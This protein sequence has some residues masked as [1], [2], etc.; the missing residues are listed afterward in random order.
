MASR[1]ILSLGLEVVLA[2]GRILGGLNKLKKD[3]TGYDLKNI[4]VGA[5]GTLG[6]ITAAVVKLFPQPRA[7]ASA[8]VGLKSVEDALALLNLAN[9]RAGGSVTLLRDHAAHRLGVRARARRRRAQSA[10]WH[11]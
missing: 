4:F 7:R 5:E 3:N 10:G 2:D 9:E 6:I 11:A 1:A 8:F